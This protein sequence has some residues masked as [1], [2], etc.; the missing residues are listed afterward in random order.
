MEY[1]DVSLSSIFESIDQGVEVTARAIRGCLLAIHRNPFDDSLKDRWII[2]ISILLSQ[3]QELP[4]FV[5][6][7]PLS[8]IDFEY[9]IDRQPEPGRIDIVT[10]SRTCTW[11]IS[12]PSLRIKI[13][14][15]I[16]SRLFVLYISRPNNYPCPLEG[17]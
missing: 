9:K 14:C 6:K 11:T 5:I 8:S 13:R 17:I 16:D 15:L 7:K 1:T 10:P 12:S 4:V 3:S 2:R